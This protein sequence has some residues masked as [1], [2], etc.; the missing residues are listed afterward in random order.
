MTTKKNGFLFACNF[1]VSAC[2]CRIHTNFKRTRRLK[3][4]ELVYTLQLFIFQNKVDIVLKSSSKELLA[5]PFL[6]RYV[7]RNKIPSCHFRGI[8]QPKLQ[9][10]M[11]SSMQE[12]AEGS[13]VK[14]FF[15]WHFHVCA[16][17]PPIFK[18]RITYSC[19]GFTEGEQEH[20]LKEK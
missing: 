14:E 20:N 19:C 15:E 2:F 12:K 11:H 4:L 17:Q 1:L 6:I 10:L 9:K 8:K 5:S 18:W 13:K 16:H 3:K 7:P